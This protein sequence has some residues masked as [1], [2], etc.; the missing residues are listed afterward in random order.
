VEGARRFAAGT[1][2]APDETGDDPMSKAL[3]A[4]I[5]LLALVPF[6]AQAEEEKEDCTTVPQAQ[7]MSQD[8]IKA[9]VA[10]AGYKDIRSMELKG[11]CYEVY[12]FDK[13]GKRAEIYVDPA[14]ATIFKSTEEGE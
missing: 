7:W 10:D 6:A 9:K 2:D 3:Y 8:A 1:R 12:G 4:A 5:A 13:D 14:T 11:S